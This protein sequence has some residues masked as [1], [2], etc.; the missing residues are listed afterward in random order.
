MP[1]TCILHGISQAK[2]YAPRLR[3]DELWFDGLRF[4]RLIE[5]AHHEELRGETK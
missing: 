2:E 1:I 5:K 3:I 4:N